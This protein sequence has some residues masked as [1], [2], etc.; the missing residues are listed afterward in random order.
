[1][2]K[3]IVLSV[4]FLFVL[5]VSANP[6]HVAQQTGAKATTQ[7]T[8]PA[9]K[10]PATTEPAPKAKKSTKAKSAKKAPAKSPK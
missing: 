10:A 5:G 7:T 6:A 1:M 3:L 4:S 8:A 9:K 2:K